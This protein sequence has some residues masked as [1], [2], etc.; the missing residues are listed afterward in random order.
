MQI[1]NLPAS[2]FANAVWAAATRNLTSPSGV[3]SEG[4]RTITADPATTA[5][6]GA[7]VWATAARTLTSGN[8]EI[9][10]SQLQA[11]VVSS[12]FSVTSTGINNI[13]SFAGPGSGMLAMFA[14]TVTTGITGNI[15]LN[16]EVVADG[17]TSAFPIYSAASTFNT[18]ITVLAQSTS[19]TGGGLNSTANF[20]LSIG[21]NSSLTVRQN[22]TA[23]AAGAG[24][25]QWTAIYSHT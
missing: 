17:V 12:S 8:A 16:L 15:T 11:P 25:I 23:S 18:S 10:G 1:N 24:A 19:G 9:L 14:L 3:W 22:V 13:I 7:A 6:A 21:F 2:S 4:T 20:R 5:V